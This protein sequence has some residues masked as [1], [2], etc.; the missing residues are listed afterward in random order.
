MSRE[1]VPGKLLLKKGVTLPGG[2]GYWIVEV[3]QSNPHYSLDIVA[4]NVENTDQILKRKIAGFRGR[5]M[6]ERFGYNL[7]AIAR[8]IKLIPKENRIAID[9]G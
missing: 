6:L 1:I 5:K 3:L 9:H 4:Y 8:C 7:E 2:Q